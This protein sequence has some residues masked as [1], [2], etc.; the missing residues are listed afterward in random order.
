MNGIA[1][2]GL[3]RTHNLPRGNVHGAANGYSIAVPRGGVPG[4]AP[5]RCTPGVGIAPSGLQ[6]THN[7]P[8][9]NVHGAANGHSI[10]V[11]QGGVPGVAPPRCTPGVGIAP[12]GLQRT[13]N[14]PW[15]NVH[16]AANGHSIAVPRGGVPG[17]AP[18]RCTPGVGIAPN[19]LQ[20]THNLP[21][22][23]VHGAAN[24]YSIA[25]PRGGVP[26]VAPLGR[27]PVSHKEKILEWISKHAKK[28]I[29]ICRFTVGMSLILNNNDFK[30][31]SDMLDA[32]SDFTRFI[33][34]IIVTRHTQH[35]LPDP[36]RSFKAYLYDA[37]KQDIV[38]KRLFMSLASACKVFLK[39]VPKL[40]RFQTLSKLLPYFGLF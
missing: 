13:H 33:L 22:G 21:R 10:A 32:L 38:F 11:P 14:L 7:L 31:V 24:G 39:V 16:G 26:G 19:G 6:R 34:H 25:V 29:E 28:I 2:S 23:N 5:P 27:A 8:W 15:R 3:Q 40:V 18:L 37:E 4:V 12:N 20:R 30:I 9:R 36:D 1:P 17:V 35:A